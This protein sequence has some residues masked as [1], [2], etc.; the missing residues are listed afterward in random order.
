MGVGCCLCLIV[1]QNRAC[2]RERG[3]ERQRPTETE[4]KRKGEKE[5]KRGREEERKRGREEE[6]KREG[7]VLERTTHNALYATHNI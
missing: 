6:R 4:R 1:W 3:T 7:E 2:E 5:R